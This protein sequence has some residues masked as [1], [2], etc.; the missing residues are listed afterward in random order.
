ML[1]I[2]E[3]E[4]ARMKHKKWLGML[5]AF[6][7]VLSACGGGKDASSHTGSTAGSA[8]SGDL[9]VIKET[10]LLSMDSSVATDGTSFEVLAAVEEGL[11]VLD[12]QGA[13]KPALAESVDISD[14]E[15]TYTFHLRD[16][17]WSNGD[18]VTANDFVFAWRRLVD[19]DT[20]SDYSYIMEVAG[21]VNA[22]PVMKGEKPLEELG[23][24][25][26][27][28]KTLEVTLEHKV[29][30]FLKLLSFG[31]FLPINQKFVEEKGDQ[32]AQSPEN[33]LYNGPF[34]MTEWV[35]GNSFKA[36]K[37]ESYWDAAN[38]KLN[39]IN[40]KVSKDPQTSALEFDTGASDF[41]RLTGDVVG[42]Y[43]GDERMQQALGGYLWYLVGNHEAVPELNNVN[44]AKA[45]ANAFDREELANVILKDGAI[46]A[47]GFV[48]KELA[49]S[50]S[51]KDFREENGN[52][53]FNEGTEAAKA[54]AEK[55]FQELGINNLSLELL[56]EDSEESKKVAEFLQEQIQKN[57]P[58]LTI[59]LKSQPKKARLQLQQDGDFQLALH[60]WGPDYPDPMTYLDLFVTDS[61]SNY[62]RV[63]IPGYDEIIEKASSGTLSDEER[64]QVLLD[65]EKLLLKDAQGPIPVYQVGNSTMW[66]PAVTGWEY[67]TTGVS[68]YY[69]NAV[70]Q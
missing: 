60:R 48:P 59:T 54:Y 70:K 5:L 6:S 68:Y 8:A 21:V 3:K 44:L 61:S 14:D 7:L 19:P 22:G 47:Y 52:D 10:D 64:W 51:G 13:E 37:N 24:K 35:A 69:K 39:S 18:P 11:Y 17:K 32:Y 25:A 43:S 33:L 45:I 42:R 36:V 65:A 2:I 23:V 41:V 53:F 27:D 66:N 29:P 55:A 40:W 57:I 34:R 38:V 49:F 15:L 58:N 46:G 30:F 26:V 50:P 20:A 56:F 16:A 28:E 9:N 1:P 63:T 62:N 4:V 67:H 12:A 31:S